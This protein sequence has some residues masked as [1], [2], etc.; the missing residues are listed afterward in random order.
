[1]SAKDTRLYGKDLELSAGD[2]GVQTYNGLSDFRVTSGRENLR[3]AILN[4]LQTD[5]GEL[6]QH[7]DYGSNLANLLGDGIDQAKELSVKFVTESLRNEPRVKSVT[8]V[9]FTNTTKTGFDLNIEV[10][11]QDEEMPLNIIY[12]NF[13]R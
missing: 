6:P 1:M 3:M 12:P 9:G 5:R 11:L 13:L 7:Q 8:K 4:R 2:L 10:R